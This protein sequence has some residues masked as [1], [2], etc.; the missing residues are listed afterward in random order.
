MEIPLN[1]T[2]PHWLSISEFLPDPSTR[3][4]FVLTQIVLALDTAWI[5]LG[6]FSSLAAVAISAI[7]LIWRVTRVALKPLDELVTHLGFDVPQGP[8]IDLA[9]VKADGVTLHWKPADDRKTSTRYEVQV[10]G[11]TRGKVSQ[12]E[13]S[14]VISNLTPDHNY[15]FRIIAINSH[16]FKA[17]S[18]PIRLR[19]KPASSNDFYGSAQAATDSKDS[20]TVPP[21]PIIRPF[22]TL[23][24]TLVSPISAPPM[25][26][27]TSNGPSAI[28]RTFVAR[29]PSP[30]TFIPDVHVNSADDFLTSPGLEAT[31]QQLTERLEEIGKEIAEAERQVVEEEQEAEQGKVEQVKERDELRA[32][33]REKENASKDLRKKVSAAERENTA[34]QS[35]KTAQDRQLQQKISEKQKVKDD[36]ERWIRE[37]KEMHTY[38]E[39]CATQKKDFL[40]DLEQQKQEL[41]QKINDESQAMRQLEDEVKEKSQDVKKLEREKSNSPSSGDDPHHDYHLEFDE[42]D[43][44]FEEHMARMEE[45]YR[46]SHMQLEEAKL[47]CDAAY[48]SM[49]EAYERSRQMAFISGPPPAPLQPVSRANSARQRRGPSDQFITSPT[50][51]IAFPMASNPP[52]NNGMNITAP[53][54]PYG[55]SP[56][57]FFNIN[58]GMAIESRDNMGMSSLEVERLTGGAPMSPSA[59]ADLIPADLLSNA[60]EEFPNR[61]LNPPPGLSSEPRQGSNEGILPGLGA[62]GSHNMLPGLG[63]SNVQ[64]SDLHNQAPQSPASPGGSRSPSLFASPQA[65]ASNLAFHSP[66]PPKDSDGRSI[67][68]GRSIRPASGGTGPPGSRF[69]QILGLDKF[70]R[71]RGKTWTDDGLALGKLQSQ[72]MPKDHGLDEAH[73]N[74]RRNSSHSGNFFGN[75]KAGFGT[76]KPNGEEDEEE[77][78]A[79]VAPRR[80]PF[81]GFG[82]KDGWGVFGGENNRPVSPRPGS[83]HSS[84]LPRPS[85]ART[86]WSFWPSNDPLANRQSPLGAEWMQSGPL[87][88]PQPRNWG[89]RYPS[90]RPSAQVGPSGGV[91]Y[92]IQEDEDDISNHSVRPPPQAPIGTKP[93]APAAS[94][95]PIERPVT[96]SAKLN[97]AAQDFKSLFSF[98]DSKKDKSEKPSKSKKGEASSTLGTP[99]PNQLT[100]VSSSHSP[101][102]GAQDDM[103]P[104]QSRKSRDSR[105]VMTDD[106]ASSKASHDLDRTPSHQLAEVPTPTSSVAGSVGKGS[107]MQRLSRKS[108]S[109][110]FALPVFQKKS[111][112]V[113]KKEGTVEEGGM[114]EGGMMGSVD[115]LSRSG[116]AEEEK[117]A[118]DKG[119]EKR[120]WS[121]GFGFGF[122]K[123]KGKAVDEG[124]D[125]EGKEQ[126]PSVSEAS[127]ASGSEAAGDSEK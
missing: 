78:Q 6:S 18:E 15:V 3:P 27:E 58:N 40:A 21:G 1:N 2:E 47:F 106:A 64:G 16:D 55:P 57:P 28:K 91:P 105:S 24:D 38:V 14:L 84:E 39:D 94:A 11:I 81:M 7:W 34:V 70:N 67:R 117:A 25:A 107:L 48:R 110:K 42:E 114:E 83:T 118:G 92:D 46:Q 56:S 116:V 23:P 52:F 22:K 62:F 75:F 86:S 54:E 113:E 80:R 122:G 63:V 79:K 76:S 124:K 115:S 31:Q 66:E 41:Q 95:G 37:A 100:P 17:T 12:L 120:T 96:P 85:E 49:Q 72:S 10:N 101:Y 82:V 93:S 29:R 13:N 125:K 53:H 9:A 30:A 97:P 71:Q 77:A 59:G 90:R 8:R 19:T 126:T 32:A 121:T 123:G 103:S 119:K 68:S 111:R 73:L 102:L 69:A 89:S 104:P 65:S 98:G 5:F 26:R 36:T 61:T 112:A 99:D 108:S 45:D 88:Q 127:L 109:G 50:G 51:S 20:A 33:L 74:K 4:G 60:D 44:L 87:P 35:R 43:R